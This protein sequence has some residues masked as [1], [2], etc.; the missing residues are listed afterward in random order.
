[1]EF[2]NC[3]RSRSYLIIQGSKRCG[4]SECSNYLGTTTL[5]KE[6]NT[7]TVYSLMLFFLL[8]FPIHDSESYVRF[9]TIKLPE[10]TK[11]VVKIPATLENVLAEVKAVDLL[12]GEHVYAQ[13]RLESANLTSYLFKRTNNMLG[14]RYPY[15]RATKAIGIYLPEQ[16]SIVYG[17]QKEL[18]KYKKVLSYAVYADWRDAIADYKLWQQET[19]NV[20]K[21]YIEFLK[22]NYAEDPLYI[23]KIQNIAAAAMH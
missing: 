13:I 8:L 5:T 2:T 15:R 9:H 10:K 17:D 7:G 1:M 4:N 3:C 16:D 21:R 12:C 6:I 14:M 22:N 18:L 11:A 20:E 19:F 23:A